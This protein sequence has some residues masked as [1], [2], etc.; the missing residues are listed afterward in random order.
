MVLFSCLRLIRFLAVAARPPSIMPST[1]T[2]PTLWRCLWLCCAAFALQ[3]KCYFGQHNFTVLP[4]FRGFPRTICHARR[5]APCM[6]VAT[7]CNGLWHNLN[8]SQRVNFAFTMNSCF[9]PYFSPPALQRPS[10]TLKL[11]SPLIFLKTFLG[12]Q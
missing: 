11:H 2:N 5:A 3:N 8:S 1:G 12:F 9:S 7:E 6:Y 10:S 4:E